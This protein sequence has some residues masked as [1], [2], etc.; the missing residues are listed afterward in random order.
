MTRP[1]NAVEL[2]SPPDA[3]E[4]AV[5]SCDILGHSNTHGVEQVRRVTAINEIVSATIRRCRPEQ[6]VWASGGDGGHVVFR[7]DQW[8]ESAVRLV[9]DLLTWAHAERVRLRITGHVGRVASVWGADGRV[10]V[11]GSGINFAG[12]LL[13]QVNG[14]AVV[15]SDAFRRAVA[16]GHA[17][18]AVTFH[19]ERLFLDRKAQ[20]R[21]LHLMSL[22]D[23]R[24]TWPEDR[25][26]GPCLT[27]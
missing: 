7:G 4:V 1:D 8:Q 15:V 14:D 21:P 24:S 27:P 18:M 11:V 10:Q 2:V 22:G 6:V 25:D 17:G 9:W 26:T 13:R 5:V 23:V 3:E 12:W 20:P 19:D 16:G